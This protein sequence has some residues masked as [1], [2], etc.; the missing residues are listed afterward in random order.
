MSPWNP[1]PRTLTSH[2]LG[3]AC[4]RGKNDWSPLSG[5]WVPGSAGS[6]LAGNVRKP[7]WQPTLC[8]GGKFPSVKMPWSVCIC[9]L[10]AVRHLII[11]QLLQCLPLGTGIYHIIS[12]CSTILTVVQLCLASRNE[13]FHCH[14]FNGCLL[15]CC[16]GT[17]SSDSWH[18]SVLEIHRCSEAQVGRFLPNH[19]L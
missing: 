18:E 17:G 13:D 7:H 5:T 9:V 3:C 6:D 4:S 8:Q 16:F 19:I 14:Q 11:M 1:V 10:R 15:V 12:E 2:P